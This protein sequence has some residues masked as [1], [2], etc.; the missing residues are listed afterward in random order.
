V[1]RRR[2]RRGDPRA[3]P[4]ARRRAGSTASMSLRRCSAE[5]PSKSAG[6]LRGML[7]AAEPCLGRARQSSKDLGVNAAM[8]RD[9]LARRAPAPAFVDELVDLV[10]VEAPHLRRPPLTPDHPG[11]V[12]LPVDDVG[13]RVLDRPRVARGRARGAAAPVRRPQAPLQ[14][15]QG[16]ELAPCSGDDVLA[17][18]PH[19][20]NR[21]SVRASRRMNP[22]RSFVRGAPRR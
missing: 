8:P 20:S 19:G 10:D 11:R 7:L 3:R 15:V 6:P 13:E 16:R 9:H 22:A 5:W 18:V 12:R 14:V 4:S 21:V 1:P 17:R 2:D